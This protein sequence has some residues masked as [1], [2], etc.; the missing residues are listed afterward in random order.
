M[1]APAL[2]L[3]AALTLPGDPSAAPASEASAPTPAAQTAPAYL[4]PI[5]NESRGQPILVGVGGDGDVWVAAEDLATLG[6]TN[7]PG[8][9]RQVDGRALVSLR[10]LAP[11]LTFAVD[12]QALMLR[13]TADETLLQRNAVDL[14]S[15]QPPKALSVETVP[16]AFANYAVQGD[17]ERTF[18]GTVEAGVTYG[19]DLLLSSASR[20]ADGRIVR[21]LSTY[22]HED[23]PR[24]LR[25]SLGDMVT[26]PRPLGGSLILAGIGFSR[27]PSL[28]PY[29]ITAP[30]P[31]VSA[32]A[33]TPSTIEVW[34]NGALSRTIPVAPGSYD[35]SNL[36]VTTGQ[37]QVQVVVRDAFGRTQLLDASGYQ[38]QQLLARGF[39]LFDWNLGLVRRGY[40]SSS[41]DYGGLAIMGA[42]EVGVTDHLTA[43]ARVEAARG[44]AS[45]G[46]ELVLGTRAGE[47]QV[48][49]G[50]SGGDAGPGLAAVTSWRYAL[51]RGAVGLDYSWSSPGYRNTSTVVLTDRQRWRADANASV[52][53]R[54]SLSLQLT[55]S[56]VES[57]QGRRLEG[58]L[59]AFVSLRDDTLLRLGGGVSGHDHRVDPSFL[60]SLVF[61]PTSSVS[62]DAQVSTADRTTTAAVGVQRPLPA[63]EGYGYRARVQG[64]ERQRA[65]SAALQG[66]TS[67]GRFELNYQGTR[68]RGGSSDTASASAAGTLV[69]VDQT[70]FLT[71][72]S[73]D[74][75]ALVRVPDVLGVR[76]YLNNQLVG[77]TDGSGEILVPGVI[78]YIANRVSIAD[79]DVPLDHVVRE[80]ARN[81]ALPRRG[82]A[83]VTL[84]V[85]RLR[86]VHGRVHLDVSGVTTPAAFGALLVVAPSGTASSPIAGDGEFWLEDLPPGVHRAYVIW[87]DRTCA[88]ALSVPRD[89]SGIVERGDLG[90]SR[91]VERSEVPASR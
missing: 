78:P 25:L 71:R 61:L 11:A 69:L 47:F 40:G 67:F 1:I 13:M 38:A 36:P 91:F 34:V 55:A 16:G 27:D 68:G 24:L 86:A 43:G 46:A 63:A 58:D 85:S 60:V 15:V 41:A 62:V 82:A 29:T 49:L 17:T 18:T 73:T 6:L 5:L 74:A 83:L 10:S 44:L 64:T 33:S 23:R 57:A 88:F 37:N 8:A 2:A 9:R 26:A 81:I 75:F 87:N 39:H 56:A 7:V 32:F 80:T 53:L 77:R 90:C 66:Q 19:S 14:R 89:G 79:T 51:Q 65:Q 3:L 12:D 4:E 21:G 35:L 59:S 30:L 50:G 20:L 76:T 22:T 70:L 52:A 72:P 45:G 54:G 48:D 28:D 31:R 42:H 84:P